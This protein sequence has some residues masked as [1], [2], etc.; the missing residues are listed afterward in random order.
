MYRALNESGR[1]NP[2]PTKN[3]NTPEQISHQ[4]ALK[5][6]KLIRKNLALPVYPLS[7]GGRGSG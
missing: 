5:A 7:P 6:I 3:T 2:S 1:I 4:K